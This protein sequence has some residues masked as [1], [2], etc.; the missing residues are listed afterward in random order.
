MYKKL[1]NPKKTTEFGY[2]LYFFCSIV[3]LTMTPEQ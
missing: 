1:L 2:N 3:V